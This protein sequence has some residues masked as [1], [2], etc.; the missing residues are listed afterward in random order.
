MRDR[1][2]AADG[3]RNL[4]RIG[5]VAFDDIDAVAP[6]KPVEVHKRQVEYAD[7][8]PRIHQLLYEHAPHAAGAARNQN[9]RAHVRVTPFIPAFSMRF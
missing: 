1:A 2:H 6:F 4:R 7:A 8:A 5:D 3:V 9:R